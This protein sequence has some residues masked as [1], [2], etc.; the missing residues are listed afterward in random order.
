MN[1]F[2]RTAAVGILSVAPL[3]RTIV[4][5]RKAGFTPPRPM[6]TGKLCGCNAPDV[7]LQRFLLKLPL[8]LVSSISL[9]S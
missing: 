8:L 9:S 7:L 1:G 6:A 4:I 2:V 3:E 5:S